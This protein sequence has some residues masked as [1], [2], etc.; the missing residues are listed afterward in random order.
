MNADKNYQSED[1]D[2]AGSTP[3]AQEQPKIRK[4]VKFFLVHRNIRLNQMKK[5]MNLIEI[6]DRLHELLE[7]SNASEKVP[8][9][10]AQLNNNLSI[11]IDSSETENVVKSGNGEPLND[12]MEHD[13][14]IDGVVSE[15]ENAGNLT[16]VSFDAN[17]IETNEHIVEN[18]QKL[19]EKLEDVKVVTESWIAENPTETLDNEHQNR[20]VLNNETPE[21]TQRNNNF[22]YTL[23][24]AQDFLGR[25]HNLLRTSV[26]FRDGL[27]NSCDVINII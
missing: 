25:L 27:L 23:V 5:L 13:Q 12:L 10:S 1:S 15:S 20:P 7:T 19:S 16:E 18:E 14:Y 11:G 17:E 9:N 2:R 26:C 3:A 8:I 4:N 24:E 6:L 22:G 21:A